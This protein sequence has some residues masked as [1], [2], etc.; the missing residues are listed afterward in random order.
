[1]QETKT[2]SDNG[3]GADRAGRKPQAP[4]PMEDVDFLRYQLVGEKCRNAQQQLDYLEHEVARARAEVNK[5][6]SEAHRLM[7][8]LAAKYDVNF[9]EG[10]G[11]S[12]DGHIV[13][14]S[15][16]MGGN[17]LPPGVSSKG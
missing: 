8:E 9:D 6:S 3:K 7:K 13:P 4:I 1:M 15:K 14:R 17:G 10:L 11:V 12:D 2:E 16:L 5:R